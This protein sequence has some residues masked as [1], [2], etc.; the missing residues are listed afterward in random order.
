[1]HTRSH[2]EAILVID[3]EQ[4]ILDSVR[5]VLQL[6]GY[7]VLTAANGNEA[8]QVLNQERPALIISDI[9]MP[10]M[11]GYQFYQRVRN[12]PQWLWIP[13]IFLTAKGEQED[14]RY[15]KELGV[16]DYL[17]KPIEPS[18]LLAAVAGRLAR[19][20]QLEAQGGVA[21]DHKPQGKYIIGSV[22]VDLSSHIVTFYESEIDLS[23]TEFN[24]L[25]ELVVAEMA[26]V[27][28]DDLLG[29]DEDV[30]MDNRDAAG[31]L[32][33]HIRNLR[34]KLEEAGVEDDLIVNVRGVG[35][36]LALQPRRI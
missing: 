33:Y 12:N 13:F 8:L 14:V 9:M 35:Y 6:S 5:D 4:I 1:M 17:T 23:P 18:D 31:L 28:Y 36:R 3:D 19:F 30:V 21:P 10:R 20:R 2:Q 24:I 22:E 25:R 11:N 26:V 29:Y 15:G 34:R 7:R 27:A 16:E 32:R